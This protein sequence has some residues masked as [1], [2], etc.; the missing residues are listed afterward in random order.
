MTETADII[1]LK[2]K[3]IRCQFKFFGT[4]IDVFEAPFLGGIT[5]IEAPL[6]RPFTAVALTSSEVRMRMKRNEFWNPRGIR[7]DSFEGD[8]MAEGAIE[9]ENPSHHAW[10]QGVTAFSAT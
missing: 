9:I 5:I 1:E 6:L 2:N 8:W 7:G 3:S 4:P 10:L